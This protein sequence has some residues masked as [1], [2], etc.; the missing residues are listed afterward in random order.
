M[1]GQVAV[2][3]WLVSVNYDAWY[4]LSLLPSSYSIMLSA[5]PPGR[6][7]DCHLQPYDLPCYAD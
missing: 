1:R 2:K 4:L 5:A 3:S 7:Q 6:Q